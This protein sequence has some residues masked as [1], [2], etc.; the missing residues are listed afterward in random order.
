[1]DSLPVLPSETRVF[2]GRF[3]LG[4]QVPPRVPKVFGSLGLIHALGRGRDSN[5]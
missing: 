1:M 2:F 5:V 4:P 3:F